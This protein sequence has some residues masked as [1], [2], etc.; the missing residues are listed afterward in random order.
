MVSV[1][2]QFTYSINFTAVS[3]GT[4]FLI[5]KMDFFTIVW[6]EQFLFSARTFFF[7]NAVQNWGAYYTQV[8]TVD[9]SPQG[10]R[11]NSLF[12]F[13]SWATC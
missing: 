11:V 7:Q 12:G 6:H 2:K 8:N 3:S 1:S 4:N 9:P 13:A 10:P 5:Q